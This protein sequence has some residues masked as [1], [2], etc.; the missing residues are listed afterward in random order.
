VYFVVHVFNN[1]FSLL[2]PKLFLSFHTV[3]PSTSSCFAIAACRWPTWADN[4]SPDVL[5]L[6]LRQ[7]YPSASRNLM[8]RVT[9]NSIVVALLALLLAPGALLGDSQK[10]C[11]RRAGT[12][13]CDAAG[14]AAPE[15][16]DSSF[17]TNAA[18]CPMTCCASTAHA[19]FAASKFQT[20]FDHY[21]AADP[22]VR[23]QAALYSDLR[24]ANLRDRSPPSI[25]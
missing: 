12:H 3:P 17:N 9:A 19:K 11:C 24:S 21:Y 6:P 14:S 8:R 10:L 23:K 22:L 13:H 7:V 16:S 4:Y 2:K 1:C 20:S 18:K 15:Q 5:V 25:S